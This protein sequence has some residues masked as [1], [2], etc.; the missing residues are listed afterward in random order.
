MEHRIIRVARRAKSVE[1]GYCP[2]ALARMPMDPPPNT[3][4]VRRDP[5]WQ[6]LSLRSRVLLA[7][8][9][10]VLTLTSCGP[11]S[12]PPPAGTAQ[13]VTVQVARSRV[14]DAPRYVEVTGTLEAAEDVMIAAKVP[15]RVTEI[16]ADLGDAV[17]PGAALVQ[18]DPTDYELAVHQARAALDEI[19]ARLGVAAVP[20]AEFDEDSVPAVARA[21]LM[22][23]NAESKYNRTNDLATRTPGAVG[24][25]DLADLRNA[26]QTALSDLAVARRDVRSLIASA[27]SR[28]ADLAAA[29]QG[30]S[31]SRVTAPAWR[32]AQ[33][34]PAYRVAARLVTTGT[35]VREGDPLVRLVMADPIKFRGHVP[36]RFNGQVENGQR[37]LVMTEASAQ[38]VEGRVSRV[39]PEISVVGRTFEFEAIIPNRDSALKPGAFGRASVRTRTDANI[40]FVPEAALLEFA[41]TKKV[42]TVE[43]GKAREHIVES[44]PPAEG[45]IEITRGLAGEHELAVSS[46]N[47]LAEGVPVA[48]SEAAPPTSASESR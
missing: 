25:Q 14:G 13:A 45:W 36:E 28:R 48:M 19:L 3:S 18:L 46:L 17:A 38:P 22:A 35:Y 5:P 11:T 6:A 41:G 42:F 4:R 39:S 2:G 20:G 37:A 1:P 31:D 27:R 7:A 29:E 44:L 10:G 15:G 24:D 47:K 23:Q 30:L 16:L 26:W 8:L 40:T 32:H 9:G 12:T 43:G 33:P 34:P 21:V